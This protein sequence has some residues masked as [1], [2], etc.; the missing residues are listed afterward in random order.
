MGIENP[1]L[2]STEQAGE[3]DS[4]EGAKLP[5]TRWDAR[6]DRMIV[7]ADLPGGE[8]GKEY[9]FRYACRVVSA[10]EFVQPPAYATCMYDADVSA[11]TEAG[12]L[13]VRPR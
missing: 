6:D 1:N 2:A 12:S 8:E 11:Q 5:V 4:F 9:V 13:T 10:G 7:F 3:T